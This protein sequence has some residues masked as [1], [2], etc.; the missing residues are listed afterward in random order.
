VKSFKGYVPIE[1][2]SFELESPDGTRK[3]TIQC[4]AFMPGS[5]FLDFMSGIGEDVTALAKAVNDLLHAAVDP[6]NWDE[7]KAFIDDPANGIS[8]EL[9]AEVA[10]YLGE[11][12]SQ[13]PTQ[14]SAP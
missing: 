2:P 4:V 9:L 11:L 14:P 5:Q 8:L 1:K 6:A 13:R 3:L 7:F 12:Y 10:G